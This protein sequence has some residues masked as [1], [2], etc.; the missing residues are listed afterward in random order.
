MKS[1]GI[2]FGLIGKDW[3][4]KL[5]LNERMIKARNIRNN[6]RVR[7]SMLGYGYAKV[8]LL[9]QKTKTK[10]G[11]SASVNDDKVQI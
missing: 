8:A 9:A 3:I 10:N 11:L 5:V 4:L 7:Y 2:G 1:I 6:V